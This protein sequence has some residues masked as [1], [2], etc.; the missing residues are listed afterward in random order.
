FL[1]TIRR[2][3]IALFAIDEAHCISE[4]GHNFRPDYLK[5]AEITKELKA[6]HV[7]ALTATATPAV[8]E[9]ICARFEI[10]KE[11]AII[12]GFYRPNLSIWTTPVSIVERDRLLL[13]RLKSREPG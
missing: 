10:P 1:E 8:V 13:D 11:C 4:W 9:N 5:L 3:K 12:T 7:L 6:Q 2:L